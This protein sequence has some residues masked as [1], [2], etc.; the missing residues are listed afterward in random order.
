MEIEQ[1]LEKYFEGLTTS[2]EEAMLRRFFTSGNVPAN[3]MMYKPL[4]AYFDNEI[5]K[6]KPK[7]PN[8]ILWLSAAAACAAILVGSFFLVSQQNDCPATG[9]YVI[10]NGRCY[11]DEATIRSMALKTLHE[12][13]ENEDFTTGDKPSDVMNIIESQLKDFDFLMNE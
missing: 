5:K 13:A 6:S 8:Y 2:E 4:F 3:L 1:L 9:N 12:M 11:T 10:I 7:Q